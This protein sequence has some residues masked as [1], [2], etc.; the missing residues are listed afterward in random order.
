[1]EIEEE[2]SR[3]EEKIESSKRLVKTN[4]RKVEKS[5]DGLAKYRGL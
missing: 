2:S 3:S 4:V 1:M 5:L